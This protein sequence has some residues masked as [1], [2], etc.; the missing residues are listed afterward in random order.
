MAW[1]RS[2]PL[3]TDEESMQFDYKAL[4]YDKVMPYEEYKR[5]WLEYAKKEAI[6]D[7]AIGNLSAR[8]IKTYGLTDKQVNQLVEDEIARITGKPKADI[9]KAYKGKKLVEFNPETGEIRRL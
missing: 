8:G 3:P 9:A 6:A 4:G 7:E 2:Y 1:L 5:Q